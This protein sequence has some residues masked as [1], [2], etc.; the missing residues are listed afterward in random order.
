MKP[1]GVPSDRRAGSEGM[2]CSQRQGEGLEWHRTVWDLGIWGIWGHLS[3]TLSWQWA[4]D[5]A[6]CQPELWGHGDGTGKGCS[7]PFSHLVTRLGIG[8]SP[9]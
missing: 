6:G 1:P 3:V 2:G 9:C 4:G 7:H 5:S 8:N